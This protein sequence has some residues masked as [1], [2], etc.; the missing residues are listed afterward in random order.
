MLPLIL[1]SIFYYQCE[2]KKL[3]Y[4]EL[5]EYLQDNDIVMIGSYYHMLKNIYT[6]KIYL[7]FFKFFN[8]GISHMCIIKEINHIKYLYH[9]I[10][11]SYYISIHKKN[12]IKTFKPNRKDKWFIMKEPLIEVLLKN[13]TSIYQIF[14]HQLNKQITINIDKNHYKNNSIYYCTI[15][16][17]E[18]LVNNK[19]IDNTDTYFKH[20]PDEI[21]DS[22]YKSGYKSNYIVC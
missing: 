8:H 20:T 7:N 19:I 16:I 11:K 4:K 15:F 9:V 1:Y 10:P 14:R 18:L 13:K 21:I 5:Y 2:Y 3:Q 6:N 22:L 12:I 17:G